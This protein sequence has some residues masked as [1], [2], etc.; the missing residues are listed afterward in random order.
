[1]QRSRVMKWSFVVLLMAI[2]FSGAVVAQAQPAAVTVTVLHALPGFTADVY[3]NGELTLSGFEPETATDPFELPAGRY[4]IEIRDV[5]ADPSSE[6]ALAGTVRLVAGSNVSIIAGLTEDGEPEL[7]VF[8]NPTE[9]V[10]AG[11]TRLIVRNVADVASIRVVL[12]EDQIGSVAHGE[13]RIRQLPEGGPFALEATVG[14]DVAI[15]VDDF[16]LDEGTVAIVYAVGSQEQGTLDFMFQSLSRLQ[17][18]PTSV[19]TGDGGLAT[20]GRYPAWALG[21]M[22]LSTALGLASAI[23]MVRRRSTGGS[24]S[25]SR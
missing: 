1:M 4:L 5:G 13:E 20:T 10:P 25:R 21:T 2:P 3:V 22:L 14:G 8:R 12:K 11:R 17:S 16:V 6:P 15:G 23:V 18:S 19:L 24:A 9:R 7:N